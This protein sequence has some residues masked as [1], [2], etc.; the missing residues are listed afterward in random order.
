MRGNRREFNMLNNDYL[1]SYLLNS[2]ESGF[3]NSKSYWV[4]SKIKRKHYT[5]ADNWLFQSNQNSY[6]KTNSFKESKTPN[7]I[8]SKSFE[9]N[10]FDDFEIS[11]MNCNEEKTYLDKSIFNVLLN[12][13]N[14]YKTRVNLS[15]ENSIQNTVIPLSSPPFV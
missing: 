14:K 5:T 8:N 15:Q 2:N 11:E 1:K 4:M 9:N 3:R 13:A 12:T 7:I 6:Y 10:E